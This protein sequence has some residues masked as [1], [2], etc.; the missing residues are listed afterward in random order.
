MLLGK[1]DRGR[2]LHELKTFKTMKTQSSSEEEFPNMDIVRSF[3]ISA[4]KEEGA[5][6]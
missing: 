6:F 2:V 3:L 1:K 4:L 5:I